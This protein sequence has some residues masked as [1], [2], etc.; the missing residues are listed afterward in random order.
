LAGASDVLGA[1]GVK[2][3]IGA[4]AVA[5]SIATAGVGFMWAPMHHPAMKHWAPVRAELGI[6]TI[7]N[8]L[9]PLANPAG[10]RRQVMGVFAERWVEPL[11]HV[12]G[13]LGAEHAWVVHGSDGLDELTTTGPS[14]VAELKG[15]TVR[16]FDVS[17]EEVGL[18]RATPDQLKG[19]DAQVNAQA[20]RAL[21]AGAPGAYRD[22]V[23]LNSAA[24][25]VVAGR[26]ATL[27]EAAG[28]ATR[29]IDQGAALATL[30][31]M[32]EITNRKV[33]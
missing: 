27:V 31:R 13:R 6:R 1:L 20:L 9:G 3:D 29:A 24:A 28:L 32:V 10:A 2:L 22:I 14:R 21:L 23:V 30:D 26:A 7:F 4:D 12:L 11:A 17:P 19:G 25:L 15:G 16:V 5:K 8:L 18:A 33:V